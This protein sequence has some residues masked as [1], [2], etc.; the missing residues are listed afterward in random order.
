MDLPN[1][2]P[3]NYSTPL[4]SS[5]AKVNQNESN[6]IDFSP[7]ESNNYNLSKCNRDSILDNFDPLL[8]SHFRDDNDYNN[9]YSFDE[10]QSVG[11]SSIYDEYDP[12]EYLYSTH[13]DCSK[14][15]DHYNDVLSS[16]KK[17]PSTASSGPAVPP[18]KQI[19]DYQVN[20]K[21]VV[22]EGLTVVKNHCFY[23]EDFASFFSML[24]STRRQFRFAS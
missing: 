3:T 1:K 10:K 2:K 6:L 14:L 22:D 9:P 20:D 17:V 15:S 4:K 12:L 13:S 8:N 5:I 18:R 24:Y 23:D 7:D 21:Q 11:S 16:P 19:F